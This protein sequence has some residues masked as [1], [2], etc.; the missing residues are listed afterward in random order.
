MSIIG[1]TFICCIPIFVYIPLKILKYYLDLKKIQIRIFTKSRGVNS[2]KINDTLKDFEIGT[3]TYLV[4]EKAI[5][6]HLKKRYLFYLENAPNPI[7]FDEGI[8]IE[9]I[10][11]EELNALY[12]PKMLKTLNSPEKMQKEALISFMLIGFILL[13]SC[14]SI[15]QLN[16]QIKIQ[17]ETSKENLENNQKIES[18]IYYLN[19]RIEKIIENTAQ[20]TMCFICE[21]CQICQ[22]CQSMQP[23]QQIQPNQY[24]TPILPQSSIIEE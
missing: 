20:K 2:L 24:I 14:F 3:T 1:Y 16:N 9:G 17:K 10:N 4:K 8:K 15:F 5:R 23:M 13:L 7:I 21:Y 12:K 22:S 6:I 19:Y 11:S 18:L